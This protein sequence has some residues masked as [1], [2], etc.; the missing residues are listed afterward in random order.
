M[1]GLFSQKWNPDGKH[2]YIT[3]GSSGLGLSLAQILAKKGAHVSIVARNQEKL[4]NA[5]ASIEKLRV[6]PSQIFKTYALALY[7]APAAVK[8]LEL[9]CEAHGGEAPD[10]VFACAGSSKP[11]FFVE[12]VDSDLVDGMTNGYWIQAWTAWAAAKKMVKER[13]KGPKIIL[14]SSTLGYMSFLG[15]ASYSPAKH[16]LRGLAD[17][18]HSELM[19]YGIGVHIYF[20]GTMYTP[21]YDKE[22]K[23]KP[24]IMKRI[25]STD[26]GV[27]AD[28]AAQALYNGVVNGHFHITGDLITSF[29]SASTRGAV[30][31]H[32]W[33]LEGLYDMVAFIAIPIWRSS[34]DKQ[35]LAHVEEH[36]Q[37]LT[38]KGFFS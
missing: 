15:W 16:A 17:T 33:L 14:V 4:E 2:V 5:L 34:V 22:N 35:V 6:S 29:F 38:S 31:R 10:A 21:G 27:T 11:M 32:N 37:Y 3:G 9:V 19:L 23:T 25:E 18:L 1:F 13:K 8:A 28:Q 36:Q 30:P 20:P 12:M 7:S 24:E 26:E